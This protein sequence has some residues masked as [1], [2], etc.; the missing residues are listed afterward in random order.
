MHLICLPVWLSYC[1]CACMFTITSVCWHGQHK[2]KVPAMSCA[3]T[4]MHPG[5]ISLP[6]LDCCFGV[7][8]LLEEEHCPELIRSRFQLEDY[9]AYP[10]SLAKLIGSP[11]QVRAGIHQRQDR[12]HFQGR[13]GKTCAISC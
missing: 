8:R 5:K 3:L 11:Y 7:C 1:D 10:V 4:I 13:H 12:L 6:N 2:L 9:L